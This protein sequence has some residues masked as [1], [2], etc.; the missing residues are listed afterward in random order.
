MLKRGFDPMAIRYL[1][2]SSHYRKLLNF[3]FDNLEMAGQALSR[4][5]NF[6]FSL[7]NVQKP[8][9]G[10][11]EIAAQ[12]NCSQPGCFYGKSGRRFQYFRRPGSAF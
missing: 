7:K 6:V 2:I 5:K 1:L 4:I 10:M 3:S 9:E 8:G 12:I 11:P